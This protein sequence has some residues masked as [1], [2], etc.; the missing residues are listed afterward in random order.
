MTSAVMTSE[1]EV[2]KDI[3][4]WEG[5]YQASNLG[6]I[7]SLD[8][9]RTV[10]GT[11]ACKGR[12]L[13]PNDLGNGYFG[14]HLYRYGSP[15]RVTTVHRLVAEAFLPTDPERGEVNHIDGDKSN[16]R[17]SN[18]E[19]VTRVENEYHSKYV[20]GAQIKRV[21]CVTT[22]VTYPSVAEA[23]R[24]LDIS[25]SLISKCCAGTRGSTHGLE[26]RFIDDD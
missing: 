14:V 21:L 5:L 24:A 1:A 20:L 15:R 11:R 19:W 13:S 12:V 18:L 7:R 8:R 2:W 23:S 25:A 6:R 9:R 3:P 16:N 10:K 22:G 17:L 4:G 26:W